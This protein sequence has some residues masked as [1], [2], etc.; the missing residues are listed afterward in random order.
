MF[1]SVKGLFI[2]PVD[3]KAHEV[4]TL[5]KFRKFV[6]STTF[7]LA[8]R[9]YRVHMLSQ[10]S[11]T[12]IPQPE[13]ETLPRI[14]FFPFQDI[15]KGQSSEVCWLVLLNLLALNLYLDYKYLF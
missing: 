13:P 7:I 2:I 5:E 4:A 1:S 10:G 6:D 8:S 12:I 9:N 11:D 15:I 14:V 3:K